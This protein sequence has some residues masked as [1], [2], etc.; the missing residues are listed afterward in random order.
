MN[1]IL[2]K[3]LFAAFVQIVFLDTHVYIHF[4][5][6]SQATIEHRKLA[7]DLA[8]VVVKWEVQRIRDEQ[9]QGPE[10]RAQH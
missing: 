10:V 9:E 7:V 5:Y 2:N 6:I 1:K 8:E 3:V 4:Y